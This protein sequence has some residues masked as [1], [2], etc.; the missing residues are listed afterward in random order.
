MAVITDERKAELQADY[1]ELKK[2]IAAI[3]NKYSL[4]YIEVEMDFPPTLGLQHIEF[5]PKS[6]AELVELAE[7]AVAPKYVEK[8]RNLEKSYQ[9]SKLNLQ[10]QIE[11]AELARDIKITEIGEKYG[12]I[13]NETY[14]K[15]C[16]N[17][18]RFST[19]YENFNNM[20]MSDF[21]DES[22]EYKIQANAEID[23]LQQ[24]AQA[25]DEN[26]QK[27]VAS[28]EEQKTIEKVFKTLDMQEKQ[29]KRME[30]VQRYNQSLDEKEIKY[31][32]SCK[33]ALQAAIQAEYERGLQAAKL[34]AEL[35]ESGVHQQII[36]EKLV[37]CRTTFRLFTRSEA[38]YV[39]ELDSF[40][41]T[42]LES[43]YSAFMEWVNTVLPDR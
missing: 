28:L 21:H 4:A 43:S 24:K 14:W 22:Q 32:A 41:Q 10:H 8:M 23:L 5:V 17:G 34:Y 16:N 15:M 2:T 36:S 19:V 29:K 31:Q 11:K 9:A 18:L 33:R 3:D 37:S 25:L 26:Y 6:Q 20:C 42:N 30:S 12:D 7:K 38:H 40:V 1:A 39:L 27:N 13:Q 35:G